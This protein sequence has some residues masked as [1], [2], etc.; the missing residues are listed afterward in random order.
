MAKRIMLD[1]HSE[2]AWYTL[3]GISC[4][5]KDYRLSYLLHENLGVRLTRLDDM[6][7]YGQGAAEPMPVS[8]Y[9]WKNEEE[10]TTYFV[11]SNRNEGAWLVPQAKQ[12]AFLLLIEGE[13][14]AK[15]QESLISALRRVPNVLMAF[16]ISF[17][18]VKNYENILTDLE[19]HLNDQDDGH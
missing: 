14:K 17:D 11:L 7:F 1:I 13:F 18:T 6:P 8:L 2:P 5:L 4:H 10:F 3:I 16:P 19:L 12:A 9:R 15:Q